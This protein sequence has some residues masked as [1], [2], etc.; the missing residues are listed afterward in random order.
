MAVRELRHPPQEEPDALG[1]EE[2]GE[3]DEV[4]VAALDVEPCDVVVL[5]E[6]VAHLLVAINIFQA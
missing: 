6:Q 3:Q 5:Q 1:E 4:E 2:G